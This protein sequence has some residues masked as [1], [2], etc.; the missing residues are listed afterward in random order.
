MARRGL[1]IA[2]D[3]PAG[4]GKTTAARGLAQRLGYL[5]LD[6]GATFRAVAF[7]ALRRGVDLDDPASLHQLALKSEIRFGGDQNERIYLDGEDVTEAIRTA[8]VA[9]AASRVAIYPEV[10]KPLMEL[11]R[12]IGHEGGVVLDGRD[13]GTVVFPD[14]ELKFFLIAEA[15]VRAER[16][17]LERANE[18]G[19]TPEGV[20][21]QL[22]RRDAID[23][24]RPYAPLVRAPDA[25][26]LD[27]SRLRPEETLH[28]LEREARARISRGTGESLDGP[29]K[30][31]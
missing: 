19:I 26:E 22:R 1:I 21:E 20:G 29:R 10:R 2:I 12:R 24:A 9:E 25:I 16:R 30:I 27:T 23:S 13:I 3:G 6:T 28:R 5:Y 7:Q 14:A 15:S 31:E 17:Y 8:K 11:W 4:A 18:P